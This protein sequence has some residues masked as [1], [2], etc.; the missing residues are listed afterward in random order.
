VSIPDQKTVFTGDIILQVNQYFRVTSKSDIG[1]WIAS[2]DKIFKN[3]TEI[4]NVVA[5]HLGVLPGAVLRNFFDSLKTMGHMQ[6]QKKS[7]VER[8]RAMISASNVMEA[9]NKFKDQFLKNRNEEYFIWEGDL[10]SLTREYME[11]EKF[12][13]AMI[14]LKMCEKI[15]PNSTMVLYN[16]AKIFAKEGKNHLA[17]EAYEKMLR[18]DPTNYYYAEKIFQLKNSK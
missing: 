1:S 11:K 16:Q 2:L 12:D 7:A 5:Y 6:R 3:N 10:L 8:L 9:V 15:F 4:K 17:I 13:E 14:I 18:I